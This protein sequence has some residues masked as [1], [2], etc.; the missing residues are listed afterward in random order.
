MTKFNKTIKIIIKS[1]NN[2][3]INLPTPINISYFWN[4][5]FLL[6]I[7]FL[8]QFIRGMFLSLHYC[9]NTEYAFNRIIHIIQNVNYGWLIH[10][11]HLNGASLFFFFIYIHI[12]RGLYYNSFKLT[13]TWIRGVSILIISIATA[14]LGYVLPWGQISFWGATVITNLLTA[15]PYFGTD[16]TIWIWGGFSINNA[17]LNRFFS[18][19]FIL[20]FI[21]IILI[22]LHL[23]FLHETGSR[24]PL[25]LNSDTFKIPFHPYFSLKD[26]LSLIIILIVF[27]LIIF[28]YPYFLGEPDN[29]IPTD[30]LRTPYHI[31]PEWYFLFAY[32]ILRSVPN[33]LGG[34]IALFSSLL[35]LYI[36]PF[37]AKPK[38]RSAIF[39]PLNQIM[40]WIFI[41]SFFILTL[42]GR[43]PIEQPFINL[44]QLLSIYYFLYFLLLL[45]LFKFWDFIIY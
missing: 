23:L 45:P 28:L 27:Y 3:L 5:G 43:V 2:N 8:I 6:G 39:Y 21:L 26:L 29:F 12:G 38:I 32:A 4:F 36:L 11:I 40:F 20:P 15:I 42:L 22:I 24:N 7:S 30:P 1:F 34:V 41:N 9:P 31:Q 44:R 10:N 18:F 35:I 25:G 19:H 14:F 16:I 13:Y 17:T 37:T 33:K